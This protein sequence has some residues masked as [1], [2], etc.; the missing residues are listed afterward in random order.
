[1]SSSRGSWELPISEG[2]LSR[3]TSEMDEAHRAALPV[4]AAS[5]R[6]LSTELKDLGASGAEPVHEVRTPLARRRFLTGAGASAAMLALAACA[7]KSATTPT[8]GSAS[9]SPSAGASASSSASASASSSSGSSKYTGDL[10]AVAL[11]VALENQAVG[12]YQAALKAANA[13]KLGKVPP[14]IATFIQTAM[15]QHKDHADAWN[16]VLSSA[17]KPKITDVPLSDQAAVTKA[18]GQVKDVTGVAK[19]ALQ[20]EDQ[21]TETYVFATYNVK[22]LGGVNTAATIAPVE[23]MHAAILHYVLGQYPVPDAFIGTKKAA[24]TSLLTV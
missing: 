7:G 1:M 9:G 6:D 22:S 19:L 21:A 2:E 15:A 3:L 4:M 14:A 13:G 20:L 8:G 10:K 23:A 18:L 5:A 11:A 24:G 16:G 17:G 12:A